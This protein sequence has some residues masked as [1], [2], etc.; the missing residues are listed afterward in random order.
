MHIACFSVSEREASG[1]GPE[2]GVDNHVVRFLHRPFR[3]DFFN[4]APFD[5]ALPLLFQDDSN[6]FMVTWWGGH[7]EGVWNGHNGH[8]WGVPANTPILAAAAGNVVYADFEPPFFCPGLGETSALVVRLRHTTPGSD[9]LETVYVHLNRLDVV[10]GQSV[11]AGQQ[12][13]LSG[14]TGCTT[15]PHLHFG[16]V[17]LTQTNN[18]RPVA[19]DPFGWQGVGP[20]PWAQ[21]PEGAESLWLWQP[22]QAPDGGER[23]YRAP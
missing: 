16:V 8:D 22:G 1:G 7:I 21:H 2:P 18:G 17:R 14:S 13:G 5:H 10:T 19:I 9:I 3:G 12:I 20:D 6:S 23:L 11:Q 15:A 4:F